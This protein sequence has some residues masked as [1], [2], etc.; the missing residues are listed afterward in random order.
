MTGRD[1]IPQ[2]YFSDVFQVSVET[3]DGVWGV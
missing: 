2:I 1:H 3:V